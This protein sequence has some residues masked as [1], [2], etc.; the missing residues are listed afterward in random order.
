MEEIYLK[1]KENSNETPYVAWKKMVTTMNQHDIEHQI[2]INRD[3]IAQAN[4]FTP[5]KENQ[6]KIESIIKV[7]NQKINFLTN[8][9][10]QK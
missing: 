9:L 5:F 10:Q 7:S 1:D 2:Q 4:N 8:L 3:L 6:E